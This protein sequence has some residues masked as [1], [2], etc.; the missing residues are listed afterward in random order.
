MKLTFTFC[1]FSVFICSCNSQK[2]KLP[3]YISLEADSISIHIETKRSDISHKI[4][5]IDSVYIKLPGIDIKSKPLFSIED[6]I[7]LFAT[8]KSDKAYM[9][10]LYTIKISADY[11]LRDIKEKF[12][13][14]TQ[15]SCNCAIDIS[16]DLQ[17]LDFYTGENILLQTEDRIS[18]INSHG[19]LL[20]SIVF[21]DKKFIYSNVFDVPIEYNT[22][23]KKIYIYKYCYSCKARSSDYYSHPIESSIDPITK[24]ITEEKIKYPEIYSQFGLGFLEVVNKTSYQN[25]QFFSFFPDH[26]IYKYNIQDQDLKVY[27]GKSSYS[28][29]K[30]S[31]LDKKENKDEDVLI[32]HSIG[33]DIYYQIVYDNIN[34]RYYRL[35]MNP[36]VV[37]PKS[38]RI[39]YDS[40]MQ[41]FNEDFVIEDE[42]KMEKL[43]VFYFTFDGK[44]YTISLR[45][46][47]IVFYMYTFQ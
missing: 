25:Y 21:K 43:G 24:N 32:Q 13:D 44:L 33:S 45:K 42:V 27:G 38:Q 39:K 29:G 2:N 6:S 37:D 47:G 11:K 4:I 22:I 19:D 3:E 46:D 35:F 5:G 41:I 17:G 36:Q 16:S 15:T 20:D 26:R 9:I 30:I 7:L 12:V 14:V 28:T 40:Y 31:V 1:L 8:S 34:K 18:M 23:T 10:N